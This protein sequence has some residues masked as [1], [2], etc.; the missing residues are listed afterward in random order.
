[1]SSPAGESP[2]TGG[3]P[4][5]L[6][7]GANLAQFSLLV[8]VNALV[9]GMVGQEQ[10]V[11]PLLAEREFGLTG[12]TF[13]FTY[14]VAFGATKAAA[15]YFAGTWSDRFGRKP[16]LVVGWL[17]AVPVP[18]LLIWAP[19]WGWVVAANVLLGL[20][21]GLTWSTTVIMKIDL[22]G[23]KQRGLAMGLN[24]AAGYGA[25][26]LTSLLAGYLAAHYGLRPAPFLLGLSYAALGLGLSGLLV[27]ETRDH[28]R[29]EAAKHVGRAD[30]RHDHLHADL[31]TRQ[32]LTHTSF[33][34]PALSS[35]SQAGLVNNLN[36]GLSWGL[37]PLLFATSGLAVDQIGVLFALYPAVWG[38]GQLLT[39]GLSDRWGRKH[40]ITAGMLT[41]ATALA[42]IAVADTFALWAAAA[43][44]LGAGTAMV[45][46]TLLA[47]IGD[48]AHPAWRG[49]AV[50]VYRVWRD[51]GY[52]VGALMAGIVAD[53]WGLRAAVWLAAAL[54]ATSGLVVATRMYETHTRRTANP[55][56][57]R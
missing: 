13:L 10:T 9:G 46:P 40:L 8:A 6:G 14:V 1:M 43:M 29:L 34:E 47:V 41:Q 49:R 37:F 4:I 20:N 15:N 57:P 21:Q 44:L 16:V 17:I 11:L 18:L 54:S 31:S 30:G 3:R 52:A 19:S 53:L 12:Y 45:Y 42:I 50:G 38:I 5:T 51:A 36:F 24:E 2:S 33:R 25:V 7:L 48:V 35:A 28:A 27:R 22:V 56:R 23:P 26:A 55:G 39:G 32:I